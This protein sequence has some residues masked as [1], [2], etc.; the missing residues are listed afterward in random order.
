MLQAVKDFDIDLEPS[1][2]VG[3]LQM[4]IELGKAVGYKT[5]LVGK[6]PAVTSGEVNPNAIASDLLEAVEIILK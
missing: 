5:I 4:D 1:F 3:D 6:P 2:V